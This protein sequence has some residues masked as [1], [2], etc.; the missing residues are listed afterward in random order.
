M[1][2]FKKIGSTLAISAILL[3]GSLLGLQPAS[4]AS[5]SS[6]MVEAV[7]DQG[8]VTASTCGFYQDPYYAYYNHCGSG[9]V[10]IQI[11]MN[12]G[13]RTQ[14]VSPGVTNLGYNVGNPITYIKFAFYIGGC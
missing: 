14:C 7:S 1:K 4:A 8:V 3:G 9:N 10:K 5:T 11:D 6:Q 2:N 13:N 12:F